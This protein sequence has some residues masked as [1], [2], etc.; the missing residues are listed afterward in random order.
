MD[1]SSEHVTNVTPSADSQLVPLPGERVPTVRIELLPPAGYKSGLRAVDVE[2]GEELREIVGL[3]FGPGGPGDVT[4]KQW[5][6]DEHGRVYLHPDTREP[7]FRLLTV[8]EIAGF[9]YA[10]GY[11]PRVLFEHHKVESVSLSFTAAAECSTCKTEV[12]EDGVCP[13]CAHEGQAGGV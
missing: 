9:W 4:V 8:V 7:A 5:K 2:T 1:S 10:P 12:L 3:W 6:L 13:R 11:R